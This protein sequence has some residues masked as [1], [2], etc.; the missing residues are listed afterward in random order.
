[1]KAIFQSLIVSSVF[2]LSACDDETLADVEQTTEANISG[3]QIKSRIAFNPTDKVLSVPNDLLF[4]DTIDGTLNIPISSGEP[5]DYSNPQVALN[6]V[7]GWSTINPFTLAVDLPEGVILDAASV[8]NPS[9]VRIFEVLMGGPTA[10]GNCA[11]LPSGIACQVVGELN[12][13]EHFVSLEKNNSILIVPTQPLKGK[14]TYIVV[15]TDQLMDSNGNAL[16]GSSTYNLVKQDIDE[17]PLGSASQLGLQA[18]INSFESAVGAVGVDKQSIIYTM[19]M[20]TQ[21]TTDVL[22]TVKQLMVA[23][24]AAGGTPEPIIVADTNASVAQVLLSQGINLSTDLQAL[25]STA[26][27]FQGS[28]T[29]P[30]YLG[31]PTS[32]NIQAPINDW[33]KALCDSGATL[34]GIDSSTLPAGPLSTSD[35]ICISVGLRDLSSVLDVDTERHLTKFNPIP[36]S[37]AASDIPYINHPGIIDVQMTTPDISATTNAIRASYGLPALTETPENGWP[38]VILQHGITSKKEDMLALTGILSTFGFA[39]AAIDHPLHGSRGFDLN[40]NGIDDINASTVSATH[41]MNLASLLTTRDNLRQSTVDT[42][43]LRLSLNAVVGADIDGSN[44]SFIGHSLGS[45]TGT[46][47]LAIANTE[48]SEGE[49]A[50]DALDTL[51]NIKLASLATPG[52][53]IANFLMESPS[54]GGLIKANL[55]LT[56]SPAFKTFVDGLYPESDYTEAE[57]VATYLQFYAVLTPTQMAELNAGYAQFTFAA[58]SVTDAGDPVNFSTMLAATQTPIHLIEVVGDGDTNLSDQVVPNYV[59]TSPLAGTEAGIALLG[60]PS[61]SS[62][63]LGSGVVRFT[64]GHHSS[65]LTPN[66][67]SGN[68]DEGSARAT[69]EMQGQVATFVL[70]QGQQIKV[71]DTSVVQ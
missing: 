46:T 42:L 15:L 36:A 37:R 58:Q 69:V 65:I 41:Y 27:L 31:I 4:Q 51:F 59:T 8:S 26:N 12:F 60:L 62:D 33:W 70:S 2:A 11:Q 63:T 19:A 61:I 38:V 66:D 21:S 57:L 56:L 54:F 20:T 16:Q 14:T 10:E 39:T 35:G 6:G 30:Y 23:P 67:S 5:D 13:Q 48:L 18:I 34:S 55:T 7:D 24:I 49:D 17:K 40:N 64:D 32:D 22:N 43:G 68:A 3:V 71:T 1:M 53:G 29:L 50:S 44:V 25:Y 47:T 52:V 45:M 28:V 9:S